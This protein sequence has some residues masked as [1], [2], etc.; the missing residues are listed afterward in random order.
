MKQL[1]IGLILITLSF[2]SSSV[3]AADKVVIIPLSGAVGDAT[4][5]DVVRDK[6]FSNKT[7]KGLTGTRFPALLKKSGQTTP[8]NLNDDTFYN[9]GI[10]T[11]PRWTY[12]QPNPGGD[13]IIFKAGYGYPD[14]SC[15]LPHAFSPK[16]G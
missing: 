12:M 16:A 14:A 13:F 3:L 2:A 9:R 6:T 8:Y 1:I 10:D 5:E 4:V 15:P 11:S 7:G